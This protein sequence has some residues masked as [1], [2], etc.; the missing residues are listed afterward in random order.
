M[1]FLI[2]M[3]LSPA[4]V[5]FLA[6]EGFEAVH[7]ST[8][9]P[10]TA[11]DAELMRWAAAGGYVVITCDLDFPALLAATQRRK[12]SVVLMRS[13]VLTTRA[14]GGLL[15]A[16]LRQVGAELSAGAILSIDAGRARLRLLPLERT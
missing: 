8:V 1:K 15:V 14:V 3:N 4:W 13:D 2:D 7:W 12:P 10:G 11:S 16:A 5:D 9:G 6:G